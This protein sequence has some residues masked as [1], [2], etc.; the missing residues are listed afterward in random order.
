MSFKEKII[1]NFEIIMPACFFVNI[2]AN[3]ISFYFTANIVNSIR[4][5]ISWGI[6][7]IFNLVAS[8]VFIS[9]LHNCEKKK[10]LLISIPFIV[11][12]LLIFIAIWDSGFS[13]FAIKK[14][15]VFILLC[16]P[17]YIIAIYTQKFEIL[18]LMIGNFKWI[19]LVM[20]PFFSVCIITYFYAKITQIYIVDV[21]N[22]SYLSIAYAAYLILIFCVAD[23]WI[24]TLKKEADKKITLDLL[25][26]IVCSITIIASESRG[27]L[28]ALIIWY[29]AMLLAIFIKK[30][31][32]KNLIF[33]MLL[34]LVTIVASYSLL[35]IFNK[36]ESQGR[37]A[38]LVQE[39]KDKDI[40]TAI[41]TEASDKIIGI[42]MESPGLDVFQKIENIDID[43]NNENNVELNE[44]IKGI[45]NGSSA[46]VYLYRIAIEEAKRNWVGG[47]GPLGYQQKYGTY[48]H[49]LILEVLADFGYIIGILFMVSIFY[50][51][52]V[53]FRCA[54]YDVRALVLLVIAI[55]CVVRFMLSID[56]YTEPLL[57]WIITYAIG[58]KVFK[59]DTKCNEETIGE[60]DIKE[61]Y[62]Q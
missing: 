13:L 42:M 22:I 26:I 33:T 10:M 52:V 38:A 60:I 46:R 7:L 4:L 23:I 31:V 62:P 54:K 37:V 59:K 6:V 44:A 21:G 48:P 19:G 30:K 32:R 45:T 18:R 36:S 43:K 16:W 61:S 15:I 9:I 11:N 28:L 40:G 20:I 25:C 34:I 53:V 12:L 39:F 56:S 3:V 41:N 1:R 29:F 58:L 24:Q 2:F 27:V 14:L 57:I 8:V 5:C 49:N 51:V 55:G 35:T 50:L 17:I 47:M